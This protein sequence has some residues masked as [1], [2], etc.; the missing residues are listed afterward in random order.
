M[1]SLNVKYK[2]KD[3]LRNGPRQ[4][5]TRMEVLGHTNVTRIPGRN[6]GVFIPMDRWYLVIND[7]SIINQSMV[8]GMSKPPGKNILTWLHSCR[9]FV[10]N[11][12]RYTRFARVSFFALFSSSCLFF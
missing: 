5:A 11:T 4:H 9:Q 2:D 1:L 12:P 8:I 6:V 3:H 7:Q 10:V